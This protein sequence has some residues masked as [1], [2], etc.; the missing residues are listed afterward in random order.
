[1]TLHEHPA[2]Q[3]QGWA[4]GWRRL[5]LGAGMLVYPL[6]TAT[7]V[8]LYS[9]GP[10]AIV[11]YVIVVAFCICYLIGGGSLARGDRPS[12]WIRLG[13][14]TVFFLAVIPLAHEYAFYLCAVILSMATP[15]LR[16]RILPFAVVAAIAGVLVPWLV[17]VWHTGP[18]W[19]QGIM[20]VFTVLLVYAFSEIARANQSLLETRAEVARLA[21]DAERNRIA[22]DLHDLVGHS[23]TAITI[24]SNLAR[25]LAAKEHSPAL[26]EISEVEELSR[27]AL[28]DM[29]AAIS[30]Y[31]EVTLAGELANAREL[32]RAAG[33]TA[34]LPTAVEVT[35]ASRQELFGWVV[36]EGITNVVRHAHATRC[37]VT[38]TESR[39]EIRDDGDGSTASGGSGLAGLRERVAA[40]GGRFDAG[41]SAPRG[42]L[43][44]ASLEAVPGAAA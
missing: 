21:S 36:R 43:V 20:I 10:A 17:P 3:L 37:T 13:A 33:V 9:T 19:V 23:L 34:D 29:R 5:V 27:Q 2:T 7:G 41:P 8:G 15:V 44:R 16:R 22:R 11:G 18:G 14:M 32:L 25:Q 30:G 39:V 42:W 28:A 1:M 31:R 4:R 26:Q 38:V 6:I 35:D 12:F 24:K 40:A